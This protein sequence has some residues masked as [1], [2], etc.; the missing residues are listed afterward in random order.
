KDQLAARFS[1]SLRLELSN[2]FAS[3]VNLS[4][5]T[6]VPQ[7]GKDI[8]NK[9]VEVYNFQAVKE[10]NIIATNTIEFI[11]KQLQALTEDLDAIERKVEGYKRSNNISDLSS[12][13]SSY[14]ENTGDYASQLSRNRIQ[15]EVL[16]SIERYLNNPDGMG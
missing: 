11:D 14:V 12:E 3:V 13:L 6:P 5:T 16:E 1:S 7:K 15:M 8:L 4:L 2:K 9:L 10:K